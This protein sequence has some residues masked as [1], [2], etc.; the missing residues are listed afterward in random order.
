[1]IISTRTGIEIHRPLENPSNVQNSGAAFGLPINQDFLLIASTVVTV[2]AL[3]LYYRFWSSD[4]VLARSAISLL[5]GGA[6]G[7]L[8]DRLRLGYV[9]D[10][11]DIRLWYNFHWP[12]FN[13]ADSTIVVGVS[14]LAYSLLKK[15]YRKSC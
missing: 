14:L 13:I 1:M 3:V 11:I 8:I 15:A 7:N 6:A 9:T 5:A 2:L 4:H 10:F 12:A